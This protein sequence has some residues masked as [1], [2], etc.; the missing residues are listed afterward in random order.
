MVGDI[1]TSDE[2]Y[3]NLE[4]LC[5][6]GSRWGG[7][8][9]EKKAVEYMLE[10]FEEYGLSNPRKEPF[11]YQSWKRGWTKLE[12][13]T[14]K[15]MSLPCIG[16]PYSPS[17]SEEGIEGEFLSVGDGTH[18]EYDLVKDE[19]SGKI[20]MTTSRTP[21]YHKRWIHRCEK[22]GR[23]IQHGAKAF[24]FMNHF[25]GLG[26][27]YGSRQKRRGYQPPLK[28]YGAG[29]KSLCRPCLLRQSG[30]LLWVQDF[31][32]PGRLKSHCHDYRQYSM[33]HNQIR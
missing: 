2:S 32:F 14:P 21:P 13:I 18:N 23:A 29:Y 12:V 15:K 10:K 30:Q 19:I 22:L 3:K 9:S 17:T 26:E 31:P 4:S 16:L 25:A 11:S 33:W 8:E 27:V 6:F 20:V 5:S 24:I 28:Q 1:Y 7:L